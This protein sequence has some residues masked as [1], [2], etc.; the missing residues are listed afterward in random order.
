MHTFTVNGKLVHFDP[1]SGALQEVRQEDDS[2]IM[3]L[4]T[5]V[6][7]SVSPA[8]VAKEFEGSE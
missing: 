3:A 4:A 7:V 8:E 6:G 5:A 1:K 2:D